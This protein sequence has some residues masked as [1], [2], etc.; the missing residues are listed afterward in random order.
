MAYRH[1]VI[2]NLKYVDEVFHNIAH[3]IPHPNE[4]GYDGQY[5]SSLP[6]CECVDDRF[7]TGFGSTYEVVVNDFPKREEEVEITIFVDTWL[8]VENVAYE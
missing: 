4:Q 1:T 7:S 2:S 6:K 5:D 3:N 8:N